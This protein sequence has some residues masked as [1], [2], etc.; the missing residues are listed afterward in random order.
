M[1]RPP[2][3]GPDGQRQPES[4]VRDRLVRDW[5]VAM[6]T[7]V[8]VPVPH[9]EIERR[10]AELVDALVGVLR[11]EPF[12]PDAAARTG[13]DLVRAGFSGQTSLSRTLDL[14]A[15]SLPDLAGPTSPETDARVHA[16]LGCL[17][18]GYVQATRE[19]VFEQQEGVK[20]ALLRAKEQAERD[21]WL[22]EARF[23]EV[24]GTSAVGVAVTD[25]DGGFV[26]VNR[27]LKEIVGYTGAELTDRRLADLFH[28]DDA[29][30]LTEIYRRLRDGKSERV[31]EQWR[32]LRKDG[33]TVWSYLAVCLLRDA[34]EE[35]AY[36]VTMVE[37]IT[38]L[39]L[40]Q[41]ELRKQALH[42]A[43][44]GLP[45]RQALVPG[46]ERMVAG[47]D[48][49]TVLQLD[50]DGLGVV[51][52]GLGHGVGDEVLRRVARQ[53]GALFPADRAAL[54]ARL[55]GDQFVVAVD[56][57]AGRPDVAALVGRINEELAEPVYHGE[58]GVAAS[59][60]VGVVQRETRG[61]SAGE[62]LRAADNTLR[63]VKGQ[64]KRQWGLFDPERDAR[65]RACS[66]LAAGMSGAWEN[67]EIR[68]DHQPVVSLRADGEVLAVE[69]VLRWEHPDVG[70]VS[71][72]RCLAMAESVGLGPPIAKWL[73]REAGEQARAWGELAPA[74]GVA[75]DVHQATDPD[76]VGE[77]RGVLAEFGLAP[78][79][80]RLGF[81]TSVL[82]EENDDAWDNLRVLTGLGVRT[83]A[84]GFGLGAVDLAC[85]EE[86]PQPVVEF[87]PELGARVARRPD[88]ALARITV[89]AV[90]V[91][92]GLGVTV[93]AGGVE[94]AED[95]DWWRSA[96]ADGAWGAH[97]AA[98]GLPQGVDAR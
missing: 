81:P 90:S 84:H 10:I 86:L 59:V 62:L 93:I 53:L 70:E 15:D 75:L 66:A 79:R 89:D 26:E 20:R 51:N 31:R 23:R 21:L 49:I 88:S 40:L 3:G 92:G 37:D 77:V 7:S 64:G 69:A 96:G 34:E 25:L 32:L 12:V 55:G 5:S 8:F 50:V 87:T 83:Y 72:E 80:L 39:H 1:R 61:A 11:A 13:G 60:S 52:E 27:S 57:S 95:A 63:R 76:L 9:E 82:R 47:S 46:L 42:D 43:L 68:V 17:V 35:P 22:S 4:A 41:R 54:V 91:L 16:V 58:H 67:G 36:L 85:V 2:T 97:F 48:G 19:L 45:N 6:A 73:L 74:V 24:F 44:T 94:S 18:T 78:E 56:H 33:D 30:A 98:R 28:P 71:H 38:D 29:G 65:D 14:L